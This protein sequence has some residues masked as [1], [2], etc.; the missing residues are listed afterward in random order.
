MASSPLLA[1]SATDRAP[2]GAV[3]VAIALG[4]NLGDRRGTLDAA[5]TAL[6]GPL[7]AIAA[8]TYYDT[9]PVG[10]DAPQP[11][12]LNAAVTGTTRLSA[13]ALL[14]A[15]HAIERRLGRERPF[16]N[17]PRTIDLDL[18]L[19]DALVADEPGLVVPHPRFRERLF[20]LEPLAEIAADMVDPVTRSSVGDL[21]DSLRRARR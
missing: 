20:V 16:R 15:L 12:Y 13:R 2:D 11:R 6:D 10:V 18:I 1:G 8:S 9:A 4:S 19:Y 3:R 5:V 14:D 21:R 17:A 7:A